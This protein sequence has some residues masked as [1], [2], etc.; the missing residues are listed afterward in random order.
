MEGGGERTPFS[1]EILDELLP[2]ELDWRRLVMTYPLVALLVAGA[3]GYWLGRRSGAAIVAA[4]EAAA[5]D[6]VTG[7][8]DRVIAE[9][10]R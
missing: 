8:V 7:L 3:G 5:A 6:R 1:E 4:A 9:D 2:E 10:A